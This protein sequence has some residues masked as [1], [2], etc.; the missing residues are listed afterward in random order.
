MGTRE[1]VIGAHYA[2]HPLLHYQIPS[3]AEYQYVGWVGDSNAWATNY[4]TGNAAAIYTDEPARLDALHRRFRN[5]T[6]QNRHLRTDLL[7][8][9]TLTLIAVMRLEAAGN[10]GVGVT[11]EREWTDVAG[12]QREGILL[13]VPDTTLHPGTMAVGAFL[14]R[15]ARLLRSPHR[16]SMRQSPRIAR[17]SGRCSAR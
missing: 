1:T 7:R 11:S 3:A 6:G 16:R 4:G 10:Y 17:R 5:G 15:P 13:M 12:S 14:R 8:T 2:G 9:D